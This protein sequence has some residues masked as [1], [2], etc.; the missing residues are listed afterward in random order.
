MPKNQI[1][2]PVRTRF[3][4]LLDPHSLFGSSY[5][6]QLADAPPSCMRLVAFQFVLPAPYDD[7]CSLCTVAGQILAS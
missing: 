7:Q 2:G 5:H 1:S 6:N 4:D 3:G